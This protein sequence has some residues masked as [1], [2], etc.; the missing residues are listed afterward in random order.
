MP[1]PPPM[2]RRRFLACWAGATAAH[3]LPACSWARSDVPALLLASDAPAG[4]DPIGHLVSEKFDGVR[5]YW[6]GR[7]LCL[8]GGAPVAAPAWFS[9][10][11]PS[12]ALDGELWLGRGRFDAVSGLVRSRRVDDPTW[13]AV[14]YL[15]F[16]LPG[17]PGT[18]AERAQRLR[19]LSA[20]RPEGPWEAIA[21]STLRDR[22]ALR[23]RLAQVVDAGGEGLMLHRADAPYVTG[24]STVLLKLKPLQ[25]AEAVVLA[26]LPGRGRHLGRLGALLVRSEGGAI[27][28][29]G[30]GF[31]DALRDAP[32]PVGA[33]LTYTHRGHTSNGL[34]R[35]ASFLRLR[36][37]EA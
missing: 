10:G 23:S 7:R 6:D 33:V 31:S 1:T 14:R 4:V 8:R 26:H 12:L 15:V 20:A 30:T 9:Q 37:A 22:A 19:E 17:A 18:F 35:F 27:F 2:S 11:L 28:R 36:Q 3:V 29:L 34:P 13:R 25:D 24:R 21:Q 16:E 5:A 32:P